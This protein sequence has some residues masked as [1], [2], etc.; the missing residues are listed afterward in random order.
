MKESFTMDTL[1][2]DF[3]IFTPEQAAAYLQMDRET[4]Y[5]YIRQGKL[6]ASRLGRTYRIP[7]SNIDLLLWSARTRPDMALRDYTPEQITDFLRDDE[8]DEEAAAIA[9]RFGWPGKAAHT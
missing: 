1:E 7:K 8:L 3:D 9:Q 4:V 2:R 6:L 5:R